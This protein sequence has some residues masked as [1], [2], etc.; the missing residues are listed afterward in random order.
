MNAPPKAYRVPRLDL[1]ID[2]YLDG[3]EGARP[4]AELIAEITAGSDRLRRYPDRSSLERLLAER[5]G[6]AADQ[7]LVTAGADDGLDRVM[8]AFL[9]GGREILLPKPTFEMIERYAR[10]AGGTVRDLDWPRSGFP[11]ADLLEAASERTAVVPV[12]TPNN[13]TGT[14]IPAGVVDVLAQAL[15][16]ATLVVD[17]AYAEFDEEGPTAAALRYENAVAVRTLSK[18]WG[19]AGQRIGYAVG[20]PAMIE[21]LRAAGA[22]YPVGGLAL[23][24][25]EAWLVQGE[26]AMNAFVQRVALERDRLAARLR[27][28][29][30][31][32]YPSRANFVFA[33]FADAAAVR[34]G[35]ARRGI[36]VRAFPDNPALEDALRITCPGDEQDYTRLETA[37]AEVL[38]DGD[39]PQ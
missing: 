26:A 12:V 19:L 31:D 6:V 20:T 37:L 27:D 7:V 17:Q 16:Q 39:T 4:P 35:L 8:R 38:N 24:V 5:L 29:G 13:P 2:L 22:P 15:P 30:V 3:N 1:P 34:L 14:T 11:I 9:T 23:A 36:S 25:A 32:P 18:A 10:L 21:R 33:R 28:F